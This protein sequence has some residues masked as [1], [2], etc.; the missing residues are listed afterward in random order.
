MAKRQSADKEVFGKR[1]GGRQIFF[2]DNSSANVYDR[3]PAV[4]EVINLHLR[5][6]VKY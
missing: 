3:G 6:I 4:H 1:L 2:P 5:Y